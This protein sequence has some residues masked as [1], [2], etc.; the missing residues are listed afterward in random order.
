MYFQT[1]DNLT[2]FEALANLTKKD[3]GSGQASSSG[4]FCQFPD[5]QKAEGHQ[6]SPHGC[7]GLKEFAISSIINMK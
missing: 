2:I 3:E 6:A 5:G 4:R 7:T 1:R